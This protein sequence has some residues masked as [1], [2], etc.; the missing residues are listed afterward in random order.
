MKDIDLEAFRPAPDLDA[1]AERY[2]VIRDADV[3]TD[4]RYKCLVCNMS[5]QLSAWSPPGSQ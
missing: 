5:S 1:S 4:S 3:R 2:S